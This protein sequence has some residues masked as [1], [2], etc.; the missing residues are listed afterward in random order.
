MYTKEEKEQHE[1]RVDKL[2]EH[3]PWGYAALYC[4]KYKYANASHI[5][6]VI[7]RKVI[8]YFILDRLE[9]MFLK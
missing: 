1:A 8:D 3:L 2:K 6:S 7:N 4:K 9:K 5:H